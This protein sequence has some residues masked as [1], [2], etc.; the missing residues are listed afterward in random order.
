MRTRHEGWVNT[1][2]RSDHVTRA[3]GGQ[4]ATQTTPR[5]PDTAIALARVTHT[6][7]PNLA[8]HTAMPSISTPLAPAGFQAP[9]RN[10]STR[11]ACPHSRPNR[12]AQWT[13]A[14]VLKLF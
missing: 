10:D 4:A 5:A 8:Q 12:D 11:A 7:W 13:K 3:D 1:E 6:P 14:M 9:W 2:P